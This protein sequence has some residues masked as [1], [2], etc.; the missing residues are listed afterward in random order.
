MDNAKESPQIY[1]FSLLAGDKRE[2]EA[3]IKRAQ[4]REDVA[5][6]ERARKKRPGRLKGKFQI[7]PEFFEP[8]TDEEIKELMGE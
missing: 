8:L 1:H 7:G 6:E 3:F 4:S 2:L 5:R